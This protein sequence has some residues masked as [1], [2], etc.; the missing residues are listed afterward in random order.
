MQRLD[1]KRP[2]FPSMLPLT[3]AESKSINWFNFLSMRHC[4]RSEDGKTT[5]IYWTNNESVTVLETPAEILNRLLTLTSQIDGGD[6]IKMKIQRP[7]EFEP[8]A[9]KFHSQK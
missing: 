3:D 2:P 4:E 7:E 9:L 8:Y 6:W 1:E 5:V